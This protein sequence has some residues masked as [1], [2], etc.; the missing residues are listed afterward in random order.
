MHLIEDIKN[1]WFIVARNKVRSALTMLGIIIGV[2]SMIVI[3]SVGAGAQSLV[4]GQVT[5]LGS[6]LVGILPG[7]SDDHGPPVAVFGVVITTLTAT[8]A[9][10]IAERIPWVVAT[11]G[12]VRGA[13][14]VSVDEKVLDTTFVGVNSTLTVVEDTDVGIGRFF[15][16]EEEAAHAR[17]VVLGSD[18]AKELFGEYNPVGQKIKIKKTNFTIIGVM[19]S[20]G[21]AGFQN[22]D[23]QIFVPLP[24]AQKILLGINHVSFIRAKIDAAEH[25]D[26]S[27]AGIRELLRERHAIADPENDDFN[28][29]ST[30]QGLETI[31]TITNALTFFLTAIA[32][33]SLVV[34]GIGI[35]NIM[36]AAVEER[37][38]EIGLRKAVGATHRAIIQQFL[39]ETA[40]ITFG[41]GMVGIVFGS[42]ISALV[43]II[44]TRLGYSW[45]LAISLWS[46]ILGSVV[47]IGIGLIFGIAPARRASRLS[48]IEALRYE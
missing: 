15:T 12:Y 24:T 37:T 17:V 14:T 1:A 8:D 25:V 26:E 46:I 41:G 36:L 35:M 32:A 40:L 45:Q 18:V 27:M 20:R 4:L 31:T 38:R 11:S 39:V 5:T 19:R 13:E 9:K 6:N 2:M 34:G 3:L 30:N 29:R 7:K 16:S 47:S 42:A 22:Q 43:A 33:V 44:A 10:A 23:N 48:P 21:V 28:V